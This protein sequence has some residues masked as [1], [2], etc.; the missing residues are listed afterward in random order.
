MSPLVEVSILLQYVA[1]LSTLGMHT[2]PALSW[3]LYL[4]ATDWT[5]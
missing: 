5:C 2:H 1:R 3:S 4:I